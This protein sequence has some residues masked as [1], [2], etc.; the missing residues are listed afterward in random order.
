MIHDLTSF[1][2]FGK[3]KKEMISIHNELTREKNLVKEQRTKGKRR[4][5]SDYLKEYTKVFDRFNPTFEEVMDAVKHQ[6]SLTFDRRLH[7]YLKK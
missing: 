5:K 2:K 6:F 1:E 3:T 7:E 4:E